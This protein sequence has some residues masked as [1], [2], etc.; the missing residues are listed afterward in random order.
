M[1]P[2]VVAVVSDV[3]EESDVERVEADSGEVE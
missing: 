3:T 2:N 1:E